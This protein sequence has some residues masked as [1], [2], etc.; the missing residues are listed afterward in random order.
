MGRLR[1]RPVKEAGLC[2]CVQA[3]QREKTSGQLGQRQTLQ[4]S[5]SSDTKGTRGGMPNRQHERPIYR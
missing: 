3:G 5:S 1:G 2:V 4:K